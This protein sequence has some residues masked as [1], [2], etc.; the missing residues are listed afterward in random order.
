[1]IARQLWAVIVGLV[2]GG[3]IFLMAVGLYHLL[4]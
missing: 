3:A 4:P 2:I 1:M